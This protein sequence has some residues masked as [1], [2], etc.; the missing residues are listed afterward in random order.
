MDILQGH[1]QIFTA[2]FVTK[3]NGHTLEKCRN[4]KSSR[5]Q[6]KVDTA[7]VATE[8]GDADS[9]MYA[10]CARS[11]NSNHQGLLVDTGDTSHI[12]RIV[13]K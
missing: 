4:K 10:L 3:I 2:H 9:H 6:D 11:S 5:S 1:V 12:V 7:E 13:N 8:S